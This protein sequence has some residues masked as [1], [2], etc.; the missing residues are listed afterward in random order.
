MLVPLKEYKV[1][2]WTGG[3]VLNS[4]MFDTLQE[5]RFFIAG[6]PK[7]DVYTLMQSKDIGDGSY[8]WFVLEDG[9]GRYLPALSWMYQNRQPIGYAI[10]LYV[11]YKVLK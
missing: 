5:A 8:S 4:Q 6:L 3:K 7:T 1:A 10:G 9:A 11:L 2:Y